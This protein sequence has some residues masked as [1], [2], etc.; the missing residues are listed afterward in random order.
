MGR[1]GDLSGAEEA[2]TALENEINR[3]LPVLASYA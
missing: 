3:L 1:K 2:W